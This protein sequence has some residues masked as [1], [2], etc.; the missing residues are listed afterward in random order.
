MKRILTILFGLWIGML[1][2]Q[3]TTVFAQTTTI[4]FQEDF[5]LVTPPLLPAGWV[6]PGGSWSTSSSVASSGSGLN[7]LTV[8]GGQPASVVSPTINLSGMNTGTLEY[9]AR[10]TSTYTRDSLVVSASIDGGATFSIVL[11]DRGTALPAGDGA[12]EFVS[13]ALPVELAGQ[14]SVV[15]QFAALGGSTSGSNVRIDD[16]IISGDGTAAEPDNIVGFAAAEG[17]VDPATSTFQAAVLLDFTNTEGLQG[18]QFT[19]SWDQEGVTFIDVLRGAA[20]AGEVDW[21][22]HVEAGA[23]S[24]KG[25]VLGNDL[26]SLSSGTFN[27]LFTLQFSIDP[28]TATDPIVLRLEQAVGALAVPTGDDAGLSIGQATHTVSVGATGAVFSLDVTSLNMDSLFVDNTATASVVVSNPGDSDLVISTVAGDNAL[29]SIDPSSA[30][31]SAAASQSFTVSFSPTF[32]VFGSQGGHFV[33]AHNA[34]GGSDTLRVAGVGVGGRGDVSEDGLV[35][36]LDI[37]QHVDIILDRVVPSVTQNASGDLFPFGAPDGVLDVRDL[38]VLAQAIVRAIWPDDEPIPADPGVG[39]TSINQFVSAKADEA[40]LMEVV[41]ESGMAHL[42]LDREIPLRAVQISLRTEATP[43]FEAQ[44]ALEGVSVFQHHDEKTRAIRLIMFRQ[45]GGLIAPGRHLL[46]QWSSEAASAEPLYSTAV[47]GRLNRVAV[48]FKE[49]IA[50]HAGEVD[51][52]PA[53]FAAELP[54]PNPFYTGRDGMVS[55]PIALAASEQVTAEIV[56]LLGRR[57]AVIA[58]A[59]MQ[60][61]YHRLAWDGRE[62][63]GAGVAS[64]LYFVRIEAAGERVV[65][66]VIV[67]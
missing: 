60:P 11:L 58:D 19:V 27:P 54:Y 43:V 64:G 49:T 10:R 24:L 42:Y 18:L 13:I 63:D 48:G 55:I 29:F 3:Q 31:V 23:S 17:T 53:T 20:I 45:D 9:L 62:A 32:T 16:V 57:I 5:D 28:L 1:S 25:V 61:G 52:V 34:A 14:A 4:F 41:E 36:V 8:A 15:L 35:D 50:T 67:E 33:F 2:V 51:D 40:V 39:K 56:D 30:T 65:R 59:T 12:Y 46:A 66:M 22:V 38:T 26:Q 37:A 7:N 6:D 21:Q 47:D 44:L